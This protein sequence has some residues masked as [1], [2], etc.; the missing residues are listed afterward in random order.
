MG[1]TD[2]L[3]GTSLDESYRYC[4]RLARRTGRNF[5]FSFLT[6]P[7]PLMRDMC[8]LYAF[9][10]V[11][12]DLGDDPSR[13]VL[14]RGAA[15]KSWRSALAESLSGASSSDPVLPALVDVVC[16]HQIPAEHLHAVITG[17]E[18]DLDPQG[19][20]TFDDLA[21]Y[22]DHVAGAV[23]LCCI[24]VW[25]F[26]HPAA[27]E[28]AIDCGRALQLTNIIRDLGEDARMGRVY[29]PREDLQRFKYSADELSHGVRNRSFRE[30]MAFQ[31]G[32]ARDYY[33]RSLPLHEMLDPPGRPILSAMLQ[34]YSGLLKEVEHRDYDVFSCR[35]TLSVPRKLRIALGC[36]VRPNR[37]P[38]P[39]AVSQGH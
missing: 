10:R 1:R 37:S 29:L 4:R 20:E 28:R 16:R 7:R 15:L 36:M 38:G 6:L 18:M 33:T 31:A 19:F 17:V 22:C 26:H 34:I 3:M 24:H 25:G 8:A 2:R 13:S 5:Y 9:M 30:L 32:R 14:E 39:L 23:G 21:T 11:T 27:R 12:D 35:V